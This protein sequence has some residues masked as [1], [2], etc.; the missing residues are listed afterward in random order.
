[1]ASQSKNISTISVKPENLLASIAEKPKLWK[2]IFERFLLAS[3]WYSA[4]G[5]KLVG[6]K[7]IQSYTF[8]HQEN[9]H[10]LLLECEFEKK[11][12][13][14]YVLPIAALQ[15]KVEEQFSQTFPHG[16]IAP[17]QVENAKGIFVD[18]LFSQE[19]RQALLAFLL[20][21]PPNKLPKTSRLS[22]V[23]Q[24]N[25]GIIY[26]KEYFLKIY[27]RVELGI[28][29]EPELLQALSE[30]TTLSC[31]PKFVAQLEMENAEQKPFT[32]ALLSKNIPHRENAWELFLGMAKK[33]LQKAN[34]ASE[35]PEPIANKDLALVHLLGQRTA[36]LHM[37]LQKL[38]GKA[39]KPEKFTPASEQAAQKNFVLTV[40]QTLKD[41][42]LAMPKWPKSMQD[43]AQFILKQAH[44]MKGVLNAAAELNT[45]LTASQKIRVHGDYHLGQVLF[46]GIDFVI[47]DFEGEPLR[48]FADRREKQS[49]LKDVAGMLRSFHYAAQSAW[50]DSGSDPKLSSWSE[51]WFQ[52]FQRA[53]LGAYFSAMDKTSLLPKKTSANQNTKHNKIM[54]QRELWLQAFVLE[55]A[56]YELRYEI[57][58]R[59]SW[60]MVPLM[61][62]LNL[63]E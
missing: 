40:N 32:V 10:I 4:K 46:N 26:G 20:E 12:T 53:F 42:R 5:K 36:E 28:N 30:Q 45:E 15:G 29:P 21:E 50:I 9:F 11:V 22:S 23:D 63:L 27:R 49:A 8:H 19:F 17:Y 44:K 2:P 31:I 58:N 48:N 13:E 59:P 41:M 24:S 51:F 1:M 3:R 60:A 62:I 52:S 55:K 35:G 6:I 25:S 43:K 14:T 39:F 37:S 61:G 54:A 33:Y 16:I 57:H 7:L 56:F 47:I 34:K 18:A 38:K